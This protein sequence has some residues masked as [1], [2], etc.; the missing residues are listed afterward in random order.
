MTMSDLEGHSPIASFF[1]W[2]FSLVDKIS[3]DIVTNTDRATITSRGYNHEWLQNDPRSATY[4]QIS[5]AVLKL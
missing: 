4:M 1:K 2:Q 3:T 5:F